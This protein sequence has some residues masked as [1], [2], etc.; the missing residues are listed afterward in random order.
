M[1]MFGSMAPV[2]AAGSSLLA[3]LVVQLAEWKW[4]FFM[5]V[6]TFLSGGRRLGQPAE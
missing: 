3:A 1:G 2:G 4:M 5:P 6:S